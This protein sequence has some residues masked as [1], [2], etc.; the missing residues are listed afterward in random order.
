M[1]GPSSIQ[2]HLLRRGL[3]SWAF[4]R[5]AF[6][7]ALLLTM[8]PPWTSGGFVGIGIVLL[9]SV[10]GL[11]EV[12]R[13][14]ERVLLANLGLSLPMLVEM[15]AVPALLGEIVLAVLLP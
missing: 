12:Q 7:M 1:R 14:H 11:I 13:V 4:A 2:R 10:L 6:A 15:L 8:N 5:A 3:L 9:G